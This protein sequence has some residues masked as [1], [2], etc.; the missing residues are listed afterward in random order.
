MR[1]NALKKIIT[2]AGQQIELLSPDG[3]TWSTDLPQLER[4]MKQR[5]KEMTKVLDEARKFLR[6]R[7]GL[8]EKTRL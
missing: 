2:I 6:G 5:E 7:P 3:E 8:T 1:D 4:R